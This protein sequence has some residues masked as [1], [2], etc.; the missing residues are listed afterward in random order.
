MERA[1]R[2]STPPRESKPDNLYEL[3]ELGLEYIMK[4]Q[5]KCQFKS[6]GKNISGNLRLL[7]VGDQFVVSHDVPEPYNL[8]SY[9]SGRISDWGS[10]WLS[11]NYIFLIKSPMIA[12]HWY[13]KGPCDWNDRDRD[14]VIAG[15]IFL[16]PR[17]RNGLYRPV[18]AALKK[19][20]SKRSKRKSK[21]SK[22]KSKRKR[23]KKKNQ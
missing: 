5:D 10:R 23:K 1:F 18:T 20:N 4:N 6:D 8:M 2:S 13:K 12:S 22:R 14:D 9:D 15:G 7:N 16:L 11:N 21:K 3:T 19:R 17:S